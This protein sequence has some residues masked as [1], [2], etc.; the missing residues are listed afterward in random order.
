[1]N[2]NLE[3]FYLFYLQCAKR[4]LKEETQK[5]I[6]KC[7]N[8]SLA[9]DLLAANGDKTWALEPQLS[10]VPTIILN[11]VSI[12]M[13]INYTLYRNIIFVYI[14]FFN[15]FEQQKFKNPHYT[16]LKHWFVP[17]W[18]KM[19]NVQ[20]VQRCKIK[21]TDRNTYAKVSFHL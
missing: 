9:D 7:I 19:N 3:I 13:I 16:I 20:F 6:S 5:R 10:F 15:R 14:N 1:M 18:Q 21:R 12:W 4:Y 2:D 11:G 8:S 17:I